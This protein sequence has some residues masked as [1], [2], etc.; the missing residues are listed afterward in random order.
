MPRQ[1]QK[2][3]ITRPPGFNGYRP[4]G[5]VERK[6]EAVELLF[7]EIEAI[8]LADYEFMSHHEACRYM[9]ISRATFA[10]IYENARR[11]VAKALVETKEIKTSMGDILLEKYWYV[12]NDCN[13]RFTKE[14]PAKTLNCPSCHSETNIQPIN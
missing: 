12:C 13:E 3:K 1:R 4:Y 9:G 6:K 7:E 8:R 10:R 2:R 11:K 5:S 14:K